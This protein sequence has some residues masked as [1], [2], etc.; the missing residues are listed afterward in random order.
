[1]TKLKLRFLALG[2][3]AAALI[4]AGFQ[5]VDMPFLPELKNDTTDGYKEKYE[6]I[7]VEFE[8]YKLD[9]ESIAS[10]KESSSSKISIDSS[11]EVEAVPSVF[12]IKEGEPSSVVLQNLVDAKLINDYE[13]AQNY[14]IE[15][16]QLTNIQY[17]TYALSK[18]MGYEKILD[19]II[20]QE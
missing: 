19:M 15:K 1:M 16:G 17:G 20:G 8:N 12:K 9:Q 5:L 10:T 7:S 11:S 2:F 4:L 6:S 14:L 13:K 3:F 18:D